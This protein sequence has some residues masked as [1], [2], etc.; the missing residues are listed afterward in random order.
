M[1]RKLIYNCLRIAAS[2]DGI[3]RVMVPP[4]ITEVRM[5]NKLCPVDSDGLLHIPREL[6]EW[7]KGRDVMP[8]GMPV[9]IGALY[10]FRTDNGKKS[11][12][13]VLYK[14]YG[15]EVPIKD[16]KLNL[17]AFW[18]TLEMA[19]EWGKADLETKERLAIE[20]SQKA[21]EALL[22]I[23]RKKKEKKEKDDDEGNSIKKRD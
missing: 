18:P 5:N 13:L 10:G 19:E 11:A 15:C 20:W 9:E 14:P 22:D 23:M 8:V 21:R 2:K 12:G 1:V 7:A 16:G 3:G 6:M 4:K 17:D